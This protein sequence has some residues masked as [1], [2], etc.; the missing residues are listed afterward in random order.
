MKISSI[1]ASTSFGR[2]LTTK[3]KTEFQKVQEEARKELKLD[4][5]TATIF[6]FSVPSGKNDTG[7]GTSFSP[8]AQELAGMLKTMCGVNSIQLQPQGEIS[9]YVR[10]PYS[11]TGFSL[12]M[13]IIDLNKLGTKEYGSLLTKGDLKAP[14]MNRVTNHDS[15]DYANVFAQDGQKAML[16]KA[17]SSF[18]RLPE[19][20]PL[21]QEF[22]QFKKDNSYWVE[23]DALFEATAVANGSKD[24]KTWPI[25]TPPYALLTDAPTPPE[26]T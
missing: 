7:I 19:T 1:N 15:V 14:Y 23:R 16:R 3:E 25:A 18:E 8:Q 17:Y 5:T 11:G 21:K 24:V 22:E 20:S 9:N 6:D 13:H 2:A 26:R 12:G 10:S 4:K